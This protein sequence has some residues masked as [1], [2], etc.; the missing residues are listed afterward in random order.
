MRI[1]IVEDELLVAMDAEATLCD[2]G[3]QV[4]GIAAS[5]HDA[6]RLA[7]SEHPDLVLLDIRLNGPLDGV[8]VAK[9]L[10]EDMH[11]PIVF[12]TANPDLARSPRASALGEISVLSKPFTKE[13]LLGVV[14]RVAKHP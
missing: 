3:H 7:S 2:A 6:L 14:N 5:G 1:L 12:V 8:D 4:V 11:L 9:R 10:I 13:A